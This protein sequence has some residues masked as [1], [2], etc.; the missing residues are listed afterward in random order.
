[1]N[2]TSAEPA[3]GTGAETGPAVFLDSN[4]LGYCADDHEPERQQLCR[5]HLHDLRSAGRAVI[6]TQVLQEFFV[7]GTGKLGLSVPHARRLVSEFRR[8]PTVTVTPDLVEQAI[9]CHQ[10]DR[11]AFW[12]ALIIVAAASAGCG[13]VLTED[14]NPGQTIRGVRIVPPSSNDL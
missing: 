9:D 10:S 12:D 2:Y 11:I 7:T 5:R 1:M 6:S 14:M 13:T 8:L 3:A 4:I